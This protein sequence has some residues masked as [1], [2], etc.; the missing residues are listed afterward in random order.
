MTELNLSSDEKALEN[1][2]R[3]RKVAGQH[4]LPDMEGAACESEV[5][6]PLWHVTIFKN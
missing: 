3:L 5:S 1:I 6:W 4:W 2:A